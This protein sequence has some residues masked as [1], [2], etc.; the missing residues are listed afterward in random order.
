MPGLVGLYAIL[1]PRVLVPG[2]RGETWGNRIDSI[3]NL[4]NLSLSY[5]L[6]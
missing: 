3:G 1:S 5:Y 4:S 6:F 2:L